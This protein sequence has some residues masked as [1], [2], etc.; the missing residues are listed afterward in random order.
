VVAAIDHPHD[1]QRSARATT[2]SETRWPSA[3]P[4]P[5][6]CSMR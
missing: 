3:S 1:A 2:P 5:G 4:T 6:T